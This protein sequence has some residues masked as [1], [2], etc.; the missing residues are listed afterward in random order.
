[1]ADYSTMFQDDPE[2]MQRTLAAYDTAHP[3]VAEPLAPSSPDVWQAP[4]PEQA[5]PEPQPASGE[6]DMRFTAPV[7]RPTG[8]LGQQARTLEN[9]RI[10]AANESADSIVREGDAKAEQA[11]DAAKIYGN[12]AQAADRYGQAAER[13]YNDDQERAAHYNGMIDA[14]MARLQQEPVRPGKLK[15]AFNIITGIIGAAAGGTTGEALGMLRQHV[16][17]QT[18]EDVQERAMAQQRL[19]LSGKVH[20]SI[21]RDSTNAFDASSKLVANQWLVASRQLE[22]VANESSVP[23]FREQALRLSIAAKDQARGVLEHNVNSQISQAAQARASLRPKWNQFT[24][25]ELAALE[26]S[27]KLPAEGATVLAELRKKKR[28]ASGEGENGAM[29]AEAAKSLRL[30][31]TAER[32]VGTMRD[33]LS[34]L[35]NTDSKDVPGVGPIAGHLGDWATSAEGTKLRRATRR[36]IKTMLRDESGAAISDEEAEGFMEDRGMGLTTTNADFMAGMNE[37]IDEYEQKRS[38]VR[39]AAGRGRSAE[40]ATSSDQHADIEARLGMTPRGG[41]R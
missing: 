28:D 18:E 8:S 13:Q 6:T 30:Y 17:R 39:E 3:E 11:S 34:K 26:Q 1:M 36:V 19:E 29:K 12:A 16:N 7:E 40:P 27:G 21:I 37:V 25:T 2:L 10:G 38:V 20:D 5:T 23:V 24:E 15:N 9:E 22:Q 35:K 14:D 4:Q 33:A 32:D 41:Q 31:E